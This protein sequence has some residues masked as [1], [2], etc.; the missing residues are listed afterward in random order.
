MVIISACLGNVPVQSI[1]PRPATPSTHSKLGSV[2]NSEKRGQLESVEAS[3]MA[4]IS[5]LASAPLPWVQWLS[6]KSVRLAIGRSWVR[7]PAGSLRLFFL[8][9]Q[10]L[11]EVDSAYREPLQG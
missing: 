9:L 11:Q 2:S 10:S 5:R 8:S 3:S 4:A 6:G 1:H 7:Y